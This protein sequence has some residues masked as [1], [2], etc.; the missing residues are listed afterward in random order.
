MIDKQDRGYR[1][2][3]LSLIF[4]FAV[5][6]LL[7]PLAAHGETWL[8]PVCQDER[9]ET[10]EGAR[11][12]TCP[13]CERSFTSDDLRIPVAYISL[14]TRP[15]QVVW[16]F[17]P[18]CGLYRLEG[19]VAEE[20]SR[21]VWVPWSAVDYWIPRQRIL[22]LTSGKELPMPYAM[23]PDCTKEEQP[24]ILATVADSVGDFLKGYSI[25]AQSFDEQMS[26]LFL[27]ARSPAA[28][29]S[30]RQRFITEVEAGKHPRLPRTPPR[31]HHLATPSVPS[32]VANDSLVVTLQV[33]IS[34]KGR[35]L[36]FDRLK[37]SGNEEADREALLAAHR[38]AI[39]V[40]GEMGA[41]VPS[42]YILR[43]TF[44]RGVATVEGEAADPPM[45]LEWF[46]PPM[47]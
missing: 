40:G 37:G 41:G 47:E 34:E 21:T 27:F 12:F 24:V 23:G 14:R 18:E 31:S 32:S 1:R 20:G 9:I 22:R 39:T 36:K 26:T 10:P 43:Y 29:D 46:E 45:W 42:S 25:Q 11:E 28:R 2:N 13:R 30:A 5:G 33:R 15:T 3:I 38:S 16:D 44:N 17:S 35:I 8:C 6:A 4:L 19:L 7:A